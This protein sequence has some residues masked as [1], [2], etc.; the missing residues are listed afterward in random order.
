M[1]KPNSALGAGPR[2]HDPKKINHLNIFHANGFQELLCGPMAG[3]LRLCP[4]NPVSNPARDQT[5]F[6]NFH[7]IPPW[8]HVAASELATWRP[9]IG[10]HW[11]IPQNILWNI[12]KIFCG[13]F[14]F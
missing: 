11:N 6:L 2:D 13:I 3:P 7:F 8:G 4:L 10:C 9:F 5:K 14:F 12:P 1:L